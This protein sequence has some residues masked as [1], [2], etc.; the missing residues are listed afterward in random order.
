MSAAGARLRH[1]LVR[2]VPTLVVVTVGVSGLA[3]S[4]PKAKPI[5]ESKVRTLTEGVARPGWQRQVRTPLP[6]ELVGFQWEGSRT[7]EL[8]VRS[9][10]GGRWSAWTD[11]DA[12][13]DE[14][15][16]ADSREFRGRNTAGPVFVGKGVR[17]VQVRVTE[18]NLRRLRMHAIRSE[19]SRPSGALAPA[20]ADAPQPGIITR[21]GWGADESLRNKAA[22]CEDSPEYAPRVRYA[23]VHHTAHS[24]NSNSY[25]PGDS[26]SIVRGIYQF[27]T[28][29]NGWCDIGYNFLV[30]KFGQM[31]EGRF[32]G[33]D[34]PV[35]GAHAAGF[36]TESTGVAVIG[37]YG[38]A[39]LSS[40][41]YGALK[42]LLAWKLSIH[43]V[44]P[45]TQITVTAGAGSGKYLEGTP[46]TI[47][48]ISGH[49]DVGT[50]ACPGDNIYKELPALRPDVASAAL[51]SSWR[52]AVVRGANW[53]LRNTQTTGAATASFIYGDPKDVPLFCDWD[54]NGS[55]T[56]GVFRGGVFYLR[57]DNS[58]G[59]ADWTVGFGDPGDV[60]VCGDWDGDGDDTVGLKRAGSWFLKI[61]NESGIHDIAFLYGDPADRPIAGDWDGDGTDTVGVV[62]GTHWFLADNNVAP[63]ALF[64]F[65]YGDAG[66]V[67]IV[68]DWDGNKSVT[69]GV[70]RRG[71][72]FLS[73]TVPSPVANVSFAFGDIG[74]LPRAWL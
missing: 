61:T 55:R 45:N 14:G 52:P 68:G 11:L 54:G 7:A 10:A 47:W 24:T 34:R 56:P 28:Q 20:A 58:P 49:R 64:S 57:N 23:V 40:E 17:D 3:A 69:P 51:G 36:N 26:A 65:G 21:A 62:R 29:T 18:G 25:G 46:A 33:M 73:D 5:L 1:W 30:D 4:T 15:P 50:T 6:T 48:T 67:P 41:G 22:D 16:D 72:W 44:N 42:G 53:Y 60:P 37:E 43:N 59:I 66:D 32:G 13:G 63:L 12:G 39:P 8:Q 70:V 74:D 27:H 2:A 9:L 35:I 31:F 71:V 19:D 38:A